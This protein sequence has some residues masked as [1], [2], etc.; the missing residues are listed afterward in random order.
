MGKT[1][2]SYS[3]KTNT[4]LWLLIHIHHIFKY[5]YLTNNKIFIKSSIISTRS[6]EELKSTLFLSF[7]LG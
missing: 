5:L 6:Y 4:N 2:V 1:C 7:F 3:R